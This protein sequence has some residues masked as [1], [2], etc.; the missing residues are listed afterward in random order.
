MK[1]TVVWTA[2]AERALTAIWVDAEDRRDRL[3]RV[4]HV[5]KLPAAMPG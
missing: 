5:W 2:T 1:F 4:L 3:V